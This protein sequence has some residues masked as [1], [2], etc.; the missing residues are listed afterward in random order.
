MGLPAKRSFTY[1]DLYDLPEN[2]TG[3]IID[4][5][6]HTMPRPSPKHSNVSS[7]LGGEIVPPYKFGRGGPGGWS[8]RGWCGYQFARPHADS[9]SGLSDPHFSRA[10]GNSHQCFPQPLSR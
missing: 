8:H 4:G 3:E 6:L 9:G 7:G 2:V 1:E 10:G 5:E